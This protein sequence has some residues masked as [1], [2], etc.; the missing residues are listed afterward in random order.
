MRAEGAGAA[1]AGGAW[2]ASKRSTYISESGSEHGTMG[3]TLG[4]SLV[5]T[6]CTETAISSRP[7]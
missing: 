4:A 5:S 3:F 2:Y 7:L 6:S 1:R